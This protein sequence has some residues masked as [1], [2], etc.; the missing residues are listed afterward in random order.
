MWI[1][2]ESVDKSVDEH[3]FCAMCLVDHKWAK[4]VGRMMKDGC[5][6][7]KNAVE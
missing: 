3:T 4:K 2:V 1:T 5:L 6:N 7:E